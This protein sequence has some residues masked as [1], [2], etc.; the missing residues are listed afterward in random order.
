MRFGPSGLL[1]FAKFGLFCLHFFLL[2]I[3]VMNKGIIIQRPAKHVSVLFYLWLIIMLFGFTKVEGMGQLLDMSMTIASFLL[4]FVYSILLLP[5][6]LHQNN[7][8]FGS[9]VAAVHYVVLTTLLVSILLGM[10]KPESF[11]LDPHS[12]RN[13]YYAFFLSPNV[14]GIICFLGI[15]TSLLISYMFPRKRHY[16]LFLPLYYGLIHMSGSRTAAYCA[17]AL[18]VLFIFKNHTFRIAR[19][20][21]NVPMIIITVAAVTLYLVRMLNSSD[22][23]N[24]L[25]EMLSGRIAIWTDLMKE[26]T[27]IEYWIGQGLLNTDVARDNYYISVLMDT[28]LAGLGIFLILLLYSLSFLIRTYAASREKQTFFLMIMLFVLAFYSFTESLLFTLGNILSI[29]LWCSIGL[30][31]I[32]TKRYSGGT[33]DENT[34]CDRQSGSAL[35]RSLQSKHGNGAGISR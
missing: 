16:L 31:M 14:L 11:F 12:L 18:I 30:Q 35:W 7:I 6:Y 5:N 27:A 29:F 10:G 8:S 9:F 28:G 33:G 3:S 21:N 2:L 34:A 22:M 13:R 25:N 26:N 32:G 15:C 17:L 20:L 19:L 24:S 4:L 1:Y 23:L